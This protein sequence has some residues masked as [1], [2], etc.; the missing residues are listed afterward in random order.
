VRESEGAVLSKQ[1]T[2]NKEVLMGTHTR[3]SSLRLYKLVGVLAVALAWLALSV[4]VA[5][6]GAAPTKKAPAYLSSLWTAVYETP[7]PQNPFGSGGPASGCFHLGG[8]LAPFGPS[9]VPACTVKSGTKIFEVGSSFECSTFDTAFTTY[10]QLLNCAVQ[11]DVTTAPY[12][13][14]D[15]RAVTLS[16]VVTGPIHATL[17]ADNVFGLPA[18]ESGLGAAHGWVALL[19]P[20]TPGTHTIVGSGTASFTTVVTVTRGKS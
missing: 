14:V 12:V 16:S 7:A 15:G 19:H 2:L 18:G 6:A 11:A 10:Q 3:G 8:T 1:F 13:T 5:P 4:A 17:P 9:G 20:L